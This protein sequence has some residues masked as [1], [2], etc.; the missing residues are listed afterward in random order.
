MITN[1]DL[2]AVVEKAMGELIP[3]ENASGI[4]IGDA[5]VPGGVFI[6]RSRSQVEKAIRSACEKVREARLK[7]YL[8]QHAISVPSVFSPS[9]NMKVESKTTTTKNE[10]EWFKEDPMSKHTKAVMKAAEEIIDL[11]LEHVM[12]QI[13]WT[14]NISELKHWIMGTGGNVTIADIIASTGADLIPECYKLAVKN[15]QYYYEE[16]SDAEYCQYCEKQKEDGCEPDCLFN[17]LRKVVEEK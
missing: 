9:L 5:L 15:G 14:G 3:Y 11:F 4:S 13:E 2:D 10:G 8:E 16:K 7:E 6:A 17:R 12:A 1:D